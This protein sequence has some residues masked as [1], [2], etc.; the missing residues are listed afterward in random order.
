LKAGNRDIKPETLEIDTY[1][2][3]H[4]KNYQ[5]V[6]DS[7]L[8]S[9]FH[10]RDLVAGYQ[11]IADPSWPKINSRQDYYSL[12]EH[13]R[14]ECEEVHAFVVNTLDASHP[15]C[16]RSILLEF[17][18][19]GFE[20]PEQHGFIKTQSKVIHTNCNMYKFP[21]GCFYDEDTF[22]DQ[23]TDLCHFLQMQ[24][25]SLDQDFKY[26]HQEFLRRQPYRAAKKRCDE[27]VRCIL[28]DSGYLV[29]EL[30]V[31]QEAYVRANLNKA[32]RT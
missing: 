8:D 6:L 17:F 2:K 19:I 11:A 5:C 31:I 30:D 4:N 21:F 25:D 23:M 3:L 1:N 16:P 27:I 29:P 28:H 9:F 18:R 26:L 22:A 15:H 7:L 24:F 14:Q 12:P 20:T 10:D 13:I 32:Q